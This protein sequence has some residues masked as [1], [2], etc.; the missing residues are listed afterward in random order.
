[1]TSTQPLIA[2]IKAGQEIGKITFSF[3]GKIINEQKLVA[4]KAVDEAGFIGRIADSVR[5]LIQ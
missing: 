5:L 1:M 2:P 3:D 4:A